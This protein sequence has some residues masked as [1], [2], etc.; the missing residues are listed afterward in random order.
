MNFLNLEEDRKQIKLRIAILKTWKSFSMSIP[1]II[2]VLLFISFVQVVLPKEEY[3]KIFVGNT[4]LDSFVGATLGSVSLGNPILSYIIGGEMLKDGVSLI[5]V[6]AFIISWVSV[7]ITQLPI[8]A[9]FFGKKFAIV[10]N[11]AAFFGSMF[12]GILIFLLMKI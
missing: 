1:I 3:S 11:I 6:A 2:T 12:I 7:G 8:E 5:A 4:F 9:H 10:R